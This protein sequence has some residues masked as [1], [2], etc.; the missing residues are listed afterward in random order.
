[1]KNELLEKIYFCAETFP[2]ECSPLWTKDTLY[3][4]NVLGDSETV[5]KEIAIW[6]AEMYILGL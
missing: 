1:M 3:L 6:E 4:L 5:K 2:E